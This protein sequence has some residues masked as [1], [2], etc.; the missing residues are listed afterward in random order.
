M[1]TASTR[2]SG[3]RMAQ[4]Q[5]ACIGPLM[6]IHGQGCWI[7]REHRQFLHQNRPYDSNTLYAGFERALRTWKTNHVQR[8]DGACTNRPTAAI[9]AGAQKTTAARSIA[10]RRRGGAK[11]AGDC[12]QRWQRAPI[13]KRK[14][15]RPVW[16]L[17]FRRC[18]RTLASQQRWRPALRIGAA[19]CRSSR[20]P[21]QRGRFIQASIVV[22][23]SIDAVR[24]GFHQG[25]PGR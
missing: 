7:G 5:R 15:R 4:R 24:I 18:R 11:R 8:P 23:K 10:A 25:A 6:R 13:R 17:P 2:G 12:M 3:H 22:M 14:A 21:G 1:P 9:T 19:T 16:Y 20:R